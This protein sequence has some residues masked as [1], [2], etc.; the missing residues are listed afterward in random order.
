MR[1]RNQIERLLTAAQSSI[2]S[3]NFEDC[4]KKA[5]LAQQSDPLHPGPAQLIAIADVI[6][7][8]SSTISSASSGS[9]KKSD[10]YSILGVPRFTGDLEVIK[11]RF[12]KLAALLNPRKNPYSLSGYAHGLVTKAWRVLS[13][14]AQKAQ[15][16][17]EL[18]LKLK[19]VERSEK[20]TFWTV[21]T[22][23]FYLYEYPAE[24]ENCSLRCQNEECRSV[25]TAAVSAPPPP[26]VI[27]KGDYDC[28]EGMSAG[29]RKQKMVA[30]CSKKLMGK[31]VRV[32]QVNGSVPR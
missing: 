13:N 4:R 2:D 31:G 5:L 15:F 19:S 8:F 22:H 12:E 14:P 9:S 32:L 17:E 11:T 21:C 10:Y 16:D 7:A 3:Q 27:E 24:Y 18:S 26:E 6:S 1:S 30:N 25:F 20:Q 29:M 23:C 28:L